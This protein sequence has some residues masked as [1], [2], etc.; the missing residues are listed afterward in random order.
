[1]YNEDQQEARHKRTVW[2]ASISI[3]SSKV[4]MKLRLAIAG[5][6]ESTEWVKSMEKG[7]T[8]TGLFL[9]KP[10]TMTMMVMMS[11]GVEMIY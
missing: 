11:N 1:M 4:N 5:D 9:G 7:R 2:D 6:G 10:M 8:N 3:L